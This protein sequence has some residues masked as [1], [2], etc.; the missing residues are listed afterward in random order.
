V[1][2]GNEYIH[3]ITQRTRQ[4]LRVEMEDWEGT[5]VYAEYD[6]FLVDGEDDQYRLC[7]LGQYSGN[8]S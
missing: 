5:K 6:N 1:L 3:L 4:R 7:L 8:T 2:S